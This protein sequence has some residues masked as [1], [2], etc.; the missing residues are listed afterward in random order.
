MSLVLC[1]APLRRLELAFAAFKI[2]ESGTWVAILVYAY[3]LGGPTAAALAALAQL[4][5]AALL[6]PV[7]GALADRRGAGRVLALGYALQASTA[8]A[9]A[10]ALLTG[11]PPA[12]VLGGAIWLTGC[13][14][15]TR[16]AQFAFSSAVARDAEQLT[17]VN[18][19][20][21]WIDSVGMLVAPLAAGVL[22]S[23]GGPGAVFA[24]MAP[25]LAAGCFAMRPLRD[26]AGS[27]DRAGELGQAAAALRLIVRHGD[28][29]LP[30]MLVASTFAAIGGLD[31]LYVVLAVDVLDLGGPGAGYLNAAFGAGGV[32]ALAATARLVGRRIAPALSAGA[33]AWALALLVLSQAPGLGCA[34]ALLALAGVGRSLL[35]VGGRVLLQ[36]V[37]APARIA[38]VGGALEG[39]SLAGLAAGSLLV[40]V[41]LAAGGTTAALAGVAALPA[42]VAL[43]GLRRLL[44]I[45]ERVI[46]PVA[47]R[48]DPS[49]VTA[50]FS[51]A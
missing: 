26:V 51:A 31:V 3:E 41:L 13:F 24:A 5:P 48:D 27:G 22:L 17:A 44:T 38:S 33:A 4:L 18:V 40:P 50:S 45:D 15:L 23:V 46:A 7:A 25:L 8:A 1:D 43:A 28:T 47:G 35:D 19:V 30:V 16:P 36:R 39:L 14:T 21:G 6:A 42:V 29:R 32:L 20:T 10:T 49:A 12:V 2:A 34:L 9:T 11:Q 37:V